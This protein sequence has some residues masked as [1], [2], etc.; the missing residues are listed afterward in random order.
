MK[1]ND[2]QDHFKYNIFRDIGVQIH[3]NKKSFFF[4]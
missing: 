4:N 1:I 3:Q 2:V